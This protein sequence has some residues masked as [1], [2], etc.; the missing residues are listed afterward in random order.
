VWG[1]ADTLVFEPPQPLSDSVITTQRARWFVWSPDH[2]RAVDPNF[3][4]E[5][6]PDNHD[7]GYDDVA[8]SE[9]MDFNSHTTR[10]LDRCGMDCRND[11]AIWLD[12]ERFALMG[13]T[14]AAA[15][16]SLFEPK[17]LVIDLGRGTMTRGLGRP[18]SL[19]A[20]PNR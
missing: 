14:T 18:V 16:D 17:V 15:S 13:W 3:D 10:F 19:A 11:D 12:R 20:A 6:D 7:F 8:V 1:V 9:L 5:W 4:R 2:T